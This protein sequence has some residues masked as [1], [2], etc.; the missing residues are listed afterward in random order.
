M[1]DAANVIADAV[2]AA[3]DREIER[4]KDELALAVHIAAAR[5]ARLHIAMDETHQ[6]FRASVD[7]MGAD[8]MGD[9]KNDKR[10]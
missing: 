1:R 10:P 6:L 5:R 4:V 9:T 7:R 3:K 2:T 8:I